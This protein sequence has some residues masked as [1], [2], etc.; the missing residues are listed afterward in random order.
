MSIDN[1]VHSFFGAS[2]LSADLYVQEFEKTTTFQL[3][4]LGGCLTGENH[5]GVE[6]HG[7][8]S[9]II[10][11]IVHKNKYK[12]FGYKGKQVRDNIHSSDLINCFWHFY[13]SPRI[14]EVYNIGGGRENSCSILEV[15]SF[16]KISIIW[17]F[18]TEYIDKNR[19]GDHIWWISDYS[20][21]KKHYPKWEIQV[22]LE[23]IYRKIAENELVEYKD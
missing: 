18:K 13:K 14:G 19:T 5:S 8:L 10:K 15:L 11:S 20:K 12:I 9:Y 1:C 22:K 3:F 17:K 2:K 6:L 23:D 21:F 16:L 4:P 7:F